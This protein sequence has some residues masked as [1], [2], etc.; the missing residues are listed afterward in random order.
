MVHEGTAWAEFGNVW[1]VNGANM[2]PKSLHVSVFLMTKRDKLV[3]VGKGSWEGRFGVLRH[4]H[5]G[6]GGRKRG[7]DGVDIGFRD[8]DGIE[9]L[10]VAGL[11]VRVSVVERYH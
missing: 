10:L 2:T 4:T 5:H 7:V 3:L 1:G 6:L 11:V 9:K 8:P